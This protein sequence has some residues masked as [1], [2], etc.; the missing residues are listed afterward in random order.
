MTVRWPLLLGLLAGP[1]AIAAG[2]LFGSS[3]AEDWQLAARWTARVSF[4]LF[5]ITYAASSLTRLWATPWHR[6]V[7]RGRRWWGLGFAAAHT[8]HLGALTYYLY[9]YG[10]PPTFATILGGGLAYALLFLMA[11]TSSDAAMRAMGRGWKRLHS[12]GIHWL[13]FIFAFTYL[14]R[15]LAGEE[16]PY[17]ALA[18]LVALSALGLRIAARR[19]R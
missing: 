9:T 2:F 5:M 4:P 11:L 18:L 6:S 14:G 17:A 7:L 10:E 1:A 19:R 15:V 16:L 12:A 13:W 8:V 3:P